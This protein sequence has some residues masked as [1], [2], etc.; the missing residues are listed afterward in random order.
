[1]ALYCYIVTAFLGF[2]FFLHLC[3]VFHP[4]NKLLTNNADIDDLDELEDN[5]KGT[6]TS[7]N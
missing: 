7:Q 2:N 3:L 5:N 1:M 6:S 4:K